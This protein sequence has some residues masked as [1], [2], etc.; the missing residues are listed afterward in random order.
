MK[1]YILLLLLIFVIPIS[2][3]GATY[4][5]VWDADG[6]TTIDGDAG[7]ICGVGA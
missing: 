5:V 3:F 6:S 7:G 4:S 1:K 2:A